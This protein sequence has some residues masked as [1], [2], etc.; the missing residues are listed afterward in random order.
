MDSQ[1]SLQSPPLS[2]PGGYF[3]EPVAPN[4]APPSEEARRGVSRIDGFKKPPAAAV[5]LADLDELFS[6]FRFSF[7]AS[8]T[9][10]SN[11][12]FDVKIKPPSAKQSVKVTTHLP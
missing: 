7:S 4:T 2:G 10:A 1:T 5:V 8:N 6:D 12:T 3:P 9:I 11:E